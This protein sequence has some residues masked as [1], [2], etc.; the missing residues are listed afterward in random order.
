MVGV[1]MDEHRIANL[2]NWDDRVPIHLGPDGYRLAEFDDPTWLSRVVQFDRDR[3]GDLTGLDVV[4][5]Q[6]HIGTDTVSLARLGTRSVTGYDFSAPA[7]AAARHLAQRAGT[8]AEFVVGEL[9]DAPE[10]LGRARFDL[11]YTG[12]GALNWLPDIT[13]WART[14]AALLRPGGRLHL[15]EGHP[16]LGAADDRRTDGLICSEY[17]VFGAA[18]PTRFEEPVSYAGDG[19]AVEHSVTYE[20]NWS[21]GEVTTAV[22]A[23]GLRV[24][25][26]VEHRTVP[27]N[28]LGDAMHEVGPFGEYELVDRPERLAATFTL[29]ATKDES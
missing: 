25:Q 16:H 18:G 7:I 14:V 8:H 29:T 6:C 27:W 9:Y 4:H 20:W 1:P 13:G 26:L 19:T 11:V 23:A 2:A 5:L 12:I 15:R 24:D 28:A 17:P 22:I 21:I 3:L 10:V